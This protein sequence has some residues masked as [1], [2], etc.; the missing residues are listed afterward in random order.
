MNSLLFKTFDEMSF[1]CLEGVFKFKS[2]ETGILKL[3]VLGSVSFFSRIER[4]RA[5]FGTLLNF[6]SSFEFPNV[7]LIFLFRVSVDSF[8]KICNGEVYETACFN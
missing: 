4:R 6:P 2:V 8:P 1:S 3:P 7:S 5:R